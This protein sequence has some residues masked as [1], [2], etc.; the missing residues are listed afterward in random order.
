MV[1]V[2]SL[3]CPEQ[4]FIGIPR[5]RVRIRRCVAATTPIA[6]GLAFPLSA[7]AIDPGVTYDPGT[8]AGK[9]YA[10]PIVQ[11]RAEGAGTQNQ[12]AAANT[13]FG[14]GVT[15]PGGRDGGAGG[16]SGPGA[17]N[18]SRADAQSA[19]DPNG[20]LRHRLGQAEDPEGTSLWTLGIALAVL[21]SAALFVLLLRNRREQPTG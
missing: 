19:R 16:H 18:G 1:S 3:T 17:K 15:P 10:I 4:M 7:H 21:V 2:A 8:P 11:G 13:P 9:E 5:T 6:V 12:R 20:D 14:V